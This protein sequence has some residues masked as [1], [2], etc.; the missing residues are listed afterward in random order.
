MKMPSL[1]SQ[2]R[3]PHSKKMK[4][5]QFNQ[6]SIHGALKDSPPS[7]NNITQPPNTL[8]SDEDLKTPQDAND[9]DSQRPTDL[10]SDDSSQTSDEE[11][12]ETDSTHKQHPCRY[13]WTDEDWDS[14]GYFD[15][16]NRE[17]PDIALAFEHPLLKQSSGFW[18]TD[19][20]YALIQP[21]IK[22][23]SKL[24]MLPRT[25]LFIY[26]LVYECKPLPSQFDCDGLRC[27]QF[28]MT[29]KRDP[30]S[31]VNEVK[32]IW[33][34]LSCHNEWGPA[35]PSEDRLSESGTH[36][37]CG[38]DYHPGGATA[39]GPDLKGDG[40]CGQSIFSALLN[41]QS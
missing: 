6:V 21:A 22:I 24:L 1:P 35:P 17:P 20:E 4:G 5:P 12:E 33:E 19:E 11:R 36:G 15:W 30:D 13:L 40:M 37:F 18:G 8:P 23:A 3:L 9:T 32:R 34:T 16:P 2:N 39:Q 41:H 14:L 28:R 10:L 38:N 26:S 25:N 29:T 31:Y 7:Y 27:F